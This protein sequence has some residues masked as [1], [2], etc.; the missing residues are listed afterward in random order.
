MG[1]KDV[2]GHDSL[3][4]QLIQNIESG[5]T[6]HA[7]IFSGK[8]GYG[9]L[10]MALSYAQHLISFECQSGALIDPLNHPDIHFFFPVVKKGSG[11]ASPLSKDYITDFQY[12]IQ[13]HPYGDLKD[14]SNRM[15]AG[16]KQGVI[17]VEEAHVIMKTLALK[18]FSGQSKVLIVWHAEKMT[19]PCANKLLKW[20]EEPNPK[21]TI[22][23]VSEQ[24][25]MLLQTIQSR[26]QVVRLVPLSENDILSYLVQ[27]NI[28][29]QQAKVVAKSAEGNLRNAINQVVGEDQELMFEALFIEWVRTAFR[30]KSHRSSINKLMA[31]S[32][33]VSK[34]GRESSKQFLNYSL[35]VFR[36]AMLLNYGA[37]KFVHAQ[38]TDNTFSLDKFSKF[39]G[40]HNIEDICTEIEN[41]VFHIERNG[42][43]KI[44]LTDLSIK[45]TRLLHKTQV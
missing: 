19:I 13:E 16:N 41:A 31:W 1:F 9:T 7:L 29:A 38:I 33:T 22:I 37:S 23:L 32:D 43:G 30:A 27:D 20:I 6:A 15:D 39:I 35:G 28:P 42:N 12:F 40:G 8:D 36:Q 34:L 24:Q 21:T 4:N 11:S 44:V 10:K 5:R 18:S 45:L 14:W 25:E 17:T 26:C 3:K 2:V